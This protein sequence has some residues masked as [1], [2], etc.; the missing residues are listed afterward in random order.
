MDEEIEEKKPEAQV[1]PKAAQP[2]DEGKFH[3][4]L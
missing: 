3:F 4:F 2:T 1:E